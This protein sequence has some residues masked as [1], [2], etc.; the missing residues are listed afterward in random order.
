[1]Q[2]I[3]ISSTGIHKRANLQLKWAVFPEELEF[4]L[5]LKEVGWELRVDGHVLPEMMKL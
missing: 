5:D 4:E 1:M 2:W 3:Q